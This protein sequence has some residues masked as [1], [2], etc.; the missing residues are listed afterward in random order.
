MF[1]LCS[2]RAQI[3]LHAASLGAASTGVQIV[4]LRQFMTILYGN[5]LVIGVVLAL[6]LLWMGVGSFLGHAWWKRRDPGQSIFPILLIFNLIVAIFVYGASK[7]VRHFMQVP[8]GEHL[9]FAD[10]FVFAGSVLC[11]PAMLFGFLY[12]LLARLSRTLDSKKETAA[13]IYGYEAIGTF[14]VGIALTFLLMKYSN[15]FCLFALVF[16]QL[17]LFCRKDRILALLAPLIVFALLMIP[18]TPRKFEGYLLRKYWESV[19]ETIVLRDWQFSRFGQSSI[20]EWGGEKFLYHNGTKVAALQNNI[21]NQIC[22]ATILSQHPHPQRILLIEGNAGGLALQCAKFVHVD[23]MEMDGAMFHFARRHMDSCSGEWNR[24]NIHIEVTDARRALRHIDAFWDMIILNVGAPATAL[25]NRYYTQHFFALVK[26]RLAADGIFTI[27]HFP[28]AENYLGEELLSLNK[29]LLNTLQSEF[30][31]VLALP[32]DDAIFFAADSPSLLVSTAEELEDR[33]RAFHLSQQHFIPQMFHY[34]YSQQ[35]IDDF[36]AQLNSAAETRINSDYSP[37]SYMFDFLI[38]HKI[39]RGDSAMMRLFSTNGIRLIF[40]GCILCVILSLLAS[41]HGSRAAARIRTTAFIVGFM[42]M[43][44]SMVLVLAFQTFFGYIYAWISFAT[45]TYMAGMGAATLIVNNRI[46]HL[47]A[48]RVLGRILGIAIILQL[49]LTPILTFMNSPVLYILL[50]MSAGALVGAAYPLICRLYFHATSQP[51]LGSI[52]AADVLGGAV[53]ALFITSI[54][55]PLSG[56]F[57]TL[58]FSALLCLSAWIY[59]KKRQ[60]TVA[61]S[62]RGGT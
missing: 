42:G 51:E 58:L 43:A 34:I 25:S 21:D 15:L 52:Y 53:G 33:Y 31:D 11:A 24:E 16:L 60:R 47:D 48:A 49:A 14:I 22:A 40:L 12:S 36:A 10:L 46:A 32:G 35:R 1:N 6:W 30:A 56:F 55:I 5:E 29:I 37:I 18:P 13:F 39:I 41:A 2:A 54:L 44:L 57:F 38:W 59:I 62:E 45:A 27:C 23:V 17:V 9:S 3:K 26:E 7:Y 61:M 19:D 20:L 4:L 8:Y 50:F 28:S